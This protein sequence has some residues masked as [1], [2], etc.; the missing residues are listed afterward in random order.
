M[1]LTVYAKIQDIYNKKV[2]SGL[3]RRLET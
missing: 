1:K 2:K 3:W